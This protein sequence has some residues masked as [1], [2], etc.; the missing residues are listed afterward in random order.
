MLILLGVSLLSKILLRLILLRLAL[1]RLTLRLLILPMFDF[2]R[3]ADYQFVLDWF[4]MGRSI[5]SCLSAL[6]L[7]FLF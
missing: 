3:S 7:R 4:A 1:L 6:T 5:E 2:V